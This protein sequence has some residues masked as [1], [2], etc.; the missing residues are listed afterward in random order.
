MTTDRQI[1]AQIEHLCANSLTRKPDFRVFFLGDRALQVLTQSTLPSPQLSRTLQALA[2]HLGALSCVSAAICAFDSVTLMLQPNTDAQ[3]AL[4]QVQTTLGLEF[5]RAVANKSRT[6]LIGFSRNALDIEFQSDLTALATHAKRS[7]RDWLAQFCTTH[8]TV[9][10]I[11]FKPGFP[12]LLGLPEAL[13][14]P[15]L[16]KPRIS[17]AKGSVAIGGAFAGIY[18]TQSPGGWHVLGITDAILFDVARAEPCLFGAGDLV[19]FELRER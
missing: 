14:M 15:R 6:H 1:G 12:Y 5:S 3:S 13:A 4:R 19:Q 17:V 2:R 8:F 16:A 7:E 18:P 9:A 10:M 11:G